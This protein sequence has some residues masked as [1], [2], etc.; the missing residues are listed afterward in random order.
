MK[1]TKH[2]LREIIKEELSRM[3]EGGL[4]GHYTE[5]RHEGGTP[6]ERL[7]NKLLIR[8]KVD[9]A[10]DPRRAAEMLGLGDD[11]EVVAYLADLMGNPMF[12]NPNMEE[13][14]QSGG[15]PSRPE[16]E[17]SEVSYN[18]TP[19]T[20]KAFHKKARKVAKQDIKKGEIEEYNLSFR[21]DDDRPVPNKQKRA[22]LGSPEEEPLRLSRPKHDPLDR[23]PAG[24][25]VRRRLQ[26]KGIKNYPLDK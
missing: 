4:A 15:K 21:E 3:K 7:L 16:E 8:S 19:E 14:I 2:R 10:G 5:P 23:S 12:D 13:A 25:R 20:R 9:K 17:H 18:P 6:E 26:G 24:R 1:I 22:E 11:E